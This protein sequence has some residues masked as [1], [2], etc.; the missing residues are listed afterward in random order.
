MGC[1]DECDH[2]EGRVAMQV[3]SQGQGKGS[4]LAKRDPVVTGEAIK[5]DLAA[6]GINVSK[7]TI[8]GALKHQKL[9]SHPPHNV[10]LKSKRH[11]RMRMRFI[12]AHLKDTAVQWRKVLWSGEAKMKHFSH[13]MK[14]IWRRKG[15]VYKPKNTNPIVKYGGRSIMLWGCFAGPDPGHLV[16]VHGSSVQGYFV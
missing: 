9:K 8:T 12:H 6:G 16:G 14:R 15:E 2:A 3:F 10:P 13:M 11:L 4:M 5:D 1:W 7:M